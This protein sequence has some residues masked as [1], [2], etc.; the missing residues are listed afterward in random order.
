MKYK[1]GSNKIRSEVSEKQV[2]SG[3]NVLKKETKNSKTKNREKTSTTKA[4]KQQKRQAKNRL[5]SEPRQS[6]TTNKPTQFPEIIGKDIHESQT[7]T[8]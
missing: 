3:D 8:N 4:W 6:T 2:F 1:T 7:R 5:Q